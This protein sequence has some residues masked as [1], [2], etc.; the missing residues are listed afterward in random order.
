[1]NALQTIS[2]KLQNS[3]SFQTLGRMFIGSASCCAGFTV[4][5]AVPSDVAV[6]NW[7]RNVAPSM[8]RSVIDGK[9]EST[10]LEP[11]TSAVTGRRSNQLS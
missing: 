1:M 5:V 2:L 3:V 11:A 10:G 9:P 8:V 6:A 7:K 4:C